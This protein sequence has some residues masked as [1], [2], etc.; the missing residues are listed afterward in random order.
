MKKK[1]SIT[2][3][4]FVF[5]FLEVGY[6]QTFLMQMI[7]RNKTKIG[8]R[9]LRPFYGV[10]QDVK[11]SVSSGDYEAYINFPVTNSLNT[12]VLVP[13][14]IEATDGQRRESGGRWHRSCAQGRCESRDQTDR[15][16]TSTLATR[17]R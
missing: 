7:P 14:T 13:F 4:L 9:A 11:L 10:D 2:A 16:C 8:I 15:G 17:C 5:L 6:A 3:L 1:V 12:V